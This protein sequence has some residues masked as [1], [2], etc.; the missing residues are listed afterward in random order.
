M[1][2]LNQIS[3]LRLAAPPPP[4][5]PRCRMGGWAGIAALSGWLLAGGVLPRIAAAQAP[6][7]EYDVKAAFLLNF[8]KFVEWPAEAF[9]SAQ[10]P[11]AI[12]IFGTDP[13]GRTLDEMLQDEV[14]QKRKL[15]VRRISESPPPRTCQVLFLSATD[16]NVQK[17]FRQAGPGVLTVSEASNFITDGG[18]IRFVVENRRVRFDINRAAASAAG[19]KL[20][21]QLLSV[22]RFVR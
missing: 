16:G 22:A 3:G 11:L 8:T 1:G 12:C 13:F 10:A 17:I 4:R 21:S 14:V 19:L 7:T 6:P 18:M 2:F 5:F 9:E 20:S 15:V